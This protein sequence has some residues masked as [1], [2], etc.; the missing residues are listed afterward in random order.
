MGFSTIGSSIHCL[1][2]HL[3]VRLMVTVMVVI[4]A[5]LFFYEEQ[6]TRLG[7]MYK[8]IMTT[9]SGLGQFLL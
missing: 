8:S 7:V 6:H 1:M 4:I 2:V 5:V 3:M 9:L